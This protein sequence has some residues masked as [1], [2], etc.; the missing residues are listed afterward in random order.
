MATITPTRTDI[1]GDGSVIKYAYA[2]MTNATSDVGVGIPF[3]QWADRS[4]QVTGTLGT[5]GTVTIEGSNDGGTTWHALNDPSSTTLAIN[6][7]KLEGILEV[8]ELVRPRISAGDGTTS[9][10][11]YFVLRRPNPMRT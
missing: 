8:C 6:S 7:L 9:L 1:S 11:V 3:A 5:G 4:V 10:N 2:A